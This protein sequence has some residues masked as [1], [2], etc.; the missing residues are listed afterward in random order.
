MEEQIKELYTISIYVFVW[1]GAVDILGA[2]RVRAIRG[3]HA[4]EQTV[5]RVGKTFN[6]MRILR[7]EALMFAVNKTYGCIE[8]GGESFPIQLNVY[9]HNICN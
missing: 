5:R 8:Q 1:Q 3:G 4:S 6:L 9:F 7:C 2:I